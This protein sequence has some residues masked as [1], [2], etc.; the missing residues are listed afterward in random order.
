MGNIFLFGLKIN[1]GKHT[2]IFTR[3]RGYTFEYSYVTAQ[4]Y[5]YALNCA[6]DSHDKVYEKFYYEMSRGFGR[7]IP[8]NSIT[9]ALKYIGGTINFIY[10]WLNP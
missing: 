5:K 2:T 6:L 7:P 9:Y 8:Y 4:Q 3:I 1:P 10:T